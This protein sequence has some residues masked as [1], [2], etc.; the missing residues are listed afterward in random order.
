LDKKLIHKF[1]RLFY[2]LKDRSSTLQCCFTILSNRL[3]NVSC[4]LVEEIH[5]VSYN[6]MRFRYE[7]I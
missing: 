7:R 1:I 6:Q 3:Q 2:S 4:I 5:I